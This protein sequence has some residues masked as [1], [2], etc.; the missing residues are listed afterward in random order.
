MVGSEDR[1]AAGLGG[2]TA[3]CEHL[4]VMRSNALQV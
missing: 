2:F 1:Y 4:P 3:P